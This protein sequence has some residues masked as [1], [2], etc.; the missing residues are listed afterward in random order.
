MRP[1]GYFFPAPIFV[2][3]ITPHTI[4]ASWVNMV[5]RVIE[6]ITVAVKALRAGGVWHD[7]IGAGKTADPTHIIPRIHINQP[8]A[9]VVAAVGKAPVG[10]C[11]WPAGAVAAKRGVPRWIC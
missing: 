4:M 2:W 11:V 10:N 3:V 8:Q 1:I 6:N 5:Q 7:G 9:V